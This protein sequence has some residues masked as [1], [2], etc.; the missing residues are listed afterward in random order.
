MA[1]ARVS[2]G[3][4]WK[5][6]LYSVCTYVCVCVRMRVQ[7]YPTPLLGLGQTPVAQVLEEMC[8]LFQCF[9]TMGLLFLK[10]VTPG[11]DRY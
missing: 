4:V 11:R 7:R 8:P 1:V 2:V 10:F 6:G 9:G 5:A 3:G